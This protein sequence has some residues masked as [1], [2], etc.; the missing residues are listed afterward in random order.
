MTPLIKLDMP[1]LPIEEYARRQ[2]IDLVETELL[3]EAAKLPMKAATRCEKKRFVNMV[4]LSRM[5][6]CK[7]FQHQPDPL[8]KLNMHV[9]IRSLIAINKDKQN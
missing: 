9:P 3:I 2:H 1:Y 6:L 7:E 4:T 5:R 8:E